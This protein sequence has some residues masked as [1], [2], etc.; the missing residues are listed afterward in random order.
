[1]QQLEKELMASYEKEAQKL[2]ENYIEEKS[3]L[4]PQIAQQEYLKY[5]STA[6]LNEKYKN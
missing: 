1:V 5:G 3:K 6:N 4:I 2:Y